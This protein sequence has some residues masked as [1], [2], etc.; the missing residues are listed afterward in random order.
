MLDPAADRAAKRLQDRLEASRVAYLGALVA[1]ADYA[2]EAL[3]DDP[4]G[5]VLVSNVEDARIRMKSDNLEVADLLY[6]L[7]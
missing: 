2:S 1:L 6:G 7:P 5:S 3:K 4:K